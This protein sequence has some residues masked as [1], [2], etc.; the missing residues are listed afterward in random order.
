VIAQPEEDDVVPPNMCAMATAAADHV[1]TVLR[2]GDEVPRKPA[3]AAGSLQDVDACTLLTAQDLRQ[4]PGFEDA[5]PHAGFGNWDCRWPNENGTASA[6]VIF[7]KGNA[8][9]ALAG[10][11]HFT[12]DGRD[13]YLREEG[14]G[15][16]TC[17]ANVLN[18]EYRG[19]AGD[20]A[21][22][23]L[24]VIEGDPAMPELCELA[25]TLAGPMASR[26]P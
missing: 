9:S 20:M 8:E 12:R 4:L 14:Y 7:D 22:M 21:E 18:R 1:M 10:D 6:R 23:A 24:V 19:P 26:L 3:A 11:D 5:E 25:T 15:E 16:G 17:S 13:V 2:A